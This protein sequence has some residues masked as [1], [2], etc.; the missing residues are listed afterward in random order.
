MRLVIDFHIGN[1]VFFGFISSTQKIFGL[2][3][4]VPDSD[5]AHYIFW[6]MEGCT[7]EECIRELTYIKK[8]FNLKHNIYITNNGKELSY[9]GYCFDV[10]PLR[11]LI[12]ILCTTQFVEWQFI[13]YSTN[14]GFASI[15]LSPKHDR[16]YQ[17]IV[18]T[19]E[20]EQEKL[21]DK[22]NFVIYD[23]GIEKKS[24][25]IKVKL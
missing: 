7:L 11:R 15:R 4:K 9:R 16:P 10:V 25:V 6:D 23:T 17:T 22:L 12:E 8:T 20:G 13:R 2:T 3:S 19:I 21:P 18:S 14:R 1:I 5:D 24:K